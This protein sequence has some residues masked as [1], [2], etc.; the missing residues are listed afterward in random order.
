MIVINACGTRSRR[1]K[2]LYWVLVA[3]MALSAAVVP[4]V[5]LIVGH[6]RQQTLV[7]EILELAAL[8]AFWGAQT[9]EH[10]D[11]GVPTGNERVQRADAVRP[12]LQ[13]LVPH[14]AK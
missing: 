6:W 5:G 14:S 10:W 9:F 7:L 12:A 3:I 11:G 13:K 1:L 4:I 2:A 8:V